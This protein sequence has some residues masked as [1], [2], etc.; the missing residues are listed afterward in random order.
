MKFVL[1]ITDQL[2]YD[3]QGEPR[4][5]Q[6]LTMSSDDSFYKIADTLCESTTKK[7]RQ[8]GGFAYHAD[9][10]FWTMKI[11]SQREA[12]KEC[13]PYRYGG[14]GSVQIVREEM[15]GKYST[16]SKHVLPSSTMITSTL[17]HEGQVIFFYHDDTERFL[18]VLEVQH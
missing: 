1:G 9:T 17:L 10:Q 12:M 16:K 2:P 11:T 18:K 5:N 3:W 8:L 13:S 6:M 15:V 14:G 4:W 7:E